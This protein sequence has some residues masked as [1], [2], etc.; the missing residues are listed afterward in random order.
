[1]TQAVDEEEVFRAKFVRKKETLR[2]VNPAVE[3]Q[4]CSFHFEKT[5]GVVFVAL[6]LI[7]FVYAP[8]AVIDLFSQVGE[9]TRELQF[10]IRLTALLYVGMCAVLVARK[11]LFPFVSVQK[12][13]SFGTCVLM[14]SV[15]TTE[16]MK[17]VEYRETS[18]DR[19]SYVVYF[20][21]YLVLGL[22]LQYA[23]Y[24]WIVGL[25][26]AIASTAVESQ[27]NDVLTP[28]RQ[29]LLVLPL[30]VAHLIGL[31]LLASVDRHQRKAFAELQLVSKRNKLVVV[32]KRKATLLLRNL[33]PGTVAERIQL[34]ETVAD[35]H[36]HVSVMFIDIVNFDEITR[37][38]DPLKVVEMLSYY[39]VIIDIVIE[40]AGLEKIKTF[41]SS[42]M[43]VG[44]LLEQSTGNPSRA[45][46]DAGVRIFRRLPEI[47][48]KLGPQL[49]LQVGVDTGSIVA[50]VIGKTKF[51]FDCW[52]D[53]CNYA[54]R[55]M[56]NSLINRICISEATHAQLG[57][58]FTCVERP[59]I[60]IK[61]VGLRATYLV[62]MDMPATSSFDGSSRSLADQL[63]SIGLGPTRNSKRHKLPP[64]LAGM[65]R[66]PSM[67]GLAPIEVTDNND[68]ATT[69][70]ALALDKAIFARNSTSPTAAM[71]RRSSQLLKAGLLNSSSG[72]K[73]VMSAL[74]INT[75]SPE[76]SQASLRPASRQSARST[77]SGRSN[78]RVP[79]PSAQSAPSP[80]PEESSRAPSRADKE[81]GFFAPPPEASAPAEPEPELEAVDIDTRLQK[82]FDELVL[83]PTSK[84]AGSGTMIQEFGSFTGSGKVPEAFLAAAEKLEEVSHTMPESFRPHV[85]QPSG[86]TI[87]S[88]F[89]GGAG[90]GGGDHRPLSRMPSSVAMSQQPDDSARSG[91]LRRLL[92]SSVPLTSEQYQQFQADM[93]KRAFSFRTLRVLYFPFGVAMLLFG[94]Y[95]AAFF[96]SIA[97]EMWIVRYGG[98]LP[99]YVGLLYLSS[100][101]APETNKRMAKF[102]VS[103]LGA[104]ILALR[105][106]IGKEYDPTP[107]DL[108]FF[109]Y[110]MFV[111]AMRISLGSTA[112]ILCTVSLGYVVL[113]AL[114]ASPN[115]T[116]LAMHTVVVLILGCYGNWMVSYM[117]S[118][119]WVVASTAQ[120]RATVLRQER[121]NAE[122][123]LYNV[124]PKSVVKDRD[125]VAKTYAGCSVL[126][127][128]FV[129]FT[130]VSRTMSPLHLVMML[131]ELFGSFDTMAQELQVEKIK[132]IGD[133][134][135]AVGG[136]PDPHENAA[137]AAVELAKAML[138]TV[139]EYNKH[140]DF[141]L[142]I[143]IGIATGDVVAGIIGGKS[144]T[145][146]DCW[147]STLVRAMALE[148]KAKVDGVLIDDA[149]L[150][151]LPSMAQW[152]P[153]EGHAYRWCP[154]QEPLEG[155]RVPGAVC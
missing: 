138:G 11:D 94:A 36:P 30:A 77:R 81:N 53:T 70:E 56:T 123:L 45:A 145:S 46:V 90:G 19:G 133:A 23:R 17:G 111:F 73:M 35:S 122:F 110:L 93:T 51:L 102:F 72:N 135:L 39:F 99:V 40:E 148:G 4:Y 152:E 76:S 117:E 52:G 101:R 55:M 113:G 66:N 12:F 103:W 105:V 124:L 67:S 97:L 82:S 132:T 33:L 128:D 28:E 74:S 34:G 153:A 142:H 49:Q 104:S 71:A 107:L 8:F 126:F 15:S 38:M 134:Y 9:P 112:S 78:H 26:V 75:Y 63:D 108:E 44:G 106:L 43:A 21:V 5:K 143:R 31:Y 59:P 116:R 121:E 65:M 87:A 80:I 137:V 79:G 37:Q 10:G 120:D 155:A 3:A 96:P 86:S 6:I 57:G 114:M 146:F 95:E 131:N 42:Y 62:D 149:T 14:A 154:P 64:V 61:G 147:S 2:F 41:G 69:Q 1:M 68:L 54:H 47:I 18:V 118:R 7:F 119:L 139:A 140:A 60:N 85:P 89:G 125:F 130:E 25:A 100:R 20:G 88:A 58:E 136:L 13:I 150:R 109:V 32:E 91:V 92:A 129:S 48:S 83:S 27:S 98:L 29:L 16:A 141:Q 151:K 22:F 84:E 115:V 50:G 144:R 127:A 24:F